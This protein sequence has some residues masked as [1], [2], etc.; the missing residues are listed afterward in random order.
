MLGVPHT[1][2]YSNREYKSYPPK[3]AYMAFMDLLY[4][5]HVDRQ[6]HKGEAD[7]G[8]LT[9]LQMPFVAR[10]T[11]GTPRIV[12]DVHADAVRLIGNKGKSS[13]T[14]QQ[15]LASW[16]GEALTAQKKPDSE[17]PERCKH[18]F[19]H[20]ALM[21]EK[22]AFWVLIALLGA[23]LF[24]ANGVYASWS[25]VVL[26]ALYAGGIVFS[27]LLTL[28]Q[29]NVNSGTANA[30]CS[31][32]QPHG[33]ATVINSDHGMLWGL[34]HWSEIGLAYFTVSLGALLVAP[35]VC[36]YLAYIS[37][38]CLPY[39]FWS[40]YT[41]HWRI[42]SWCTLCLC[43]QGLFWVIFAVQLI[44]GNMHSL[45]P[46]KWDVAVLLVCYALALLVYHKIVPAYFY[47]ERKSA[48]TYSVADNAADSISKL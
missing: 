1:A 38:L 42:H 9:A 15:F 36:N 29:N 41:Q 18:A 26:V 44:G 34:F 22:Y 43:V 7:M 31:M 19:M 35:Q 17:E 8:S 28:E 16:S 10:M 48:E 37:I 40:V 4:E 33:C 30:V 6:M 12:T 39:T 3:L 11:D 46:L 27:W 45:L 13:M 25:Q 21:A 47:Y 2:T 32:I 14:P 23:Y 20:A 5:Y 24:V